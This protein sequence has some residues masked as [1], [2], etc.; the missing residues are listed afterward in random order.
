[1]LRDELRDL[2]QQLETIH[3]KQG[4]PAQ[5]E[6]FRRLLVEYLEPLRVEQPQEYER[7]MQGWCKGPGAM[8]RAR[9]G[10]CRV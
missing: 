6:E 4:T 3:R 9:R 5:W 1:M 10:E 8:A 7:S 2:A